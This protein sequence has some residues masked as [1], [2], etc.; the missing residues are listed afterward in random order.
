MRLVLCDDHR[1][2]GEALAAAFEGRGYQILAVTTT[3][4]AGVTAVAVHD[5]DICLLD[6]RF[7]GAENGLDAARAITQ[8]HPRTKVLVLSWATDPQMLSEA[9]GIGVA[10]FIPKDQSVDQIADALDA[11]AAGGA[12]F[13]T[14]LHRGVAT[15]R[16]QRST[17]LLDRLTPREREIL[18]RIVDGQS[19]KQMARAMSI[20]IGTVSMYARNVITKLGVHSRLQAAA[21]VSQEGLLGQLRADEA[22]PRSPGPGDPAVPPGDLD[23]PA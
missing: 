6:L 1:I 18:A 8:H 3:A 13:D 17:H 15:R 14:G 7:P 22:G 16:G 2:L 20:T 23:V 12:V 11:I 5:P 4:T 10:G 9:M 21:L 19:T